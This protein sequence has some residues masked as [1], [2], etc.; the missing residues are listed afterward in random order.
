MGRGGDRNFSHYH[1][2][3]DRSVWSPRGVSGILLGLLLQHLVQAT[4][5]RCL[6]STRPWSVAGVRASRSKGPTETRPVPIGATWSRP[7]RLRRTLLGISDVVGTDPVGGP[8]ACLARLTALAPSERYHQKLGSRHQKLTDWDRQMILQLRR[9]LRHRPLV[10]GDNSYA[11]PVSRH[12]AGS[13]PAPLLPV[14]PRTRNPR[15][16]TAPG[17]RSLRLRATSS[18]GSNRQIPGQGI[19]LTPSQATS[20]RSP[21]SGAPRRCPCMTAP[22]TPWNRFPRLPSGTAT[23]DRPYPSAGHWSETSGVNALGTQALHRCV[24]GSSPDAGVVC[25]ALA[26]VGPLPGSTGTW[27]WKPSASS[28]IAP[29]HSPRPS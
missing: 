24:G 3:L 27:A 1:E 19:T 22:S 21:Y 18:A 25:A 20:W 17:R 11:V 8:G 29:S 2:A 28:R 26:T 13:G 23:A 7:A 9:W 6:A 16:Q 5:P 15:R 12:G 4:A 10:V 14:S